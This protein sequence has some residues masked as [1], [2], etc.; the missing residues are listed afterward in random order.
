M[1][2][3]GKKNNKG[4][5]NSWQEAFALNQ[6]NIVLMAA[7]QYT[8]DDVHELF[9]FDKKHFDNIETHEKE[10]ND[11]TRKMN[12]EYL[13]LTMSVLCSRVLDYLAEE[14]KG[15][16]KIAI[17]EFDFEE[18][19]HISVSSIAKAINKSD[20]QNVRARLKRWV[21]DTLTEAGYIKGYDREREFSQKDH[22][23]RLT[24]E[25]FEAHLPFLRECGLRSEAFDGE[26]MAH[27]RSKDETEF[28]G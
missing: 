23:V 1:F 26:I 5:L 17:D 4:P 13:R 10:V 22:E 6:R 25:G 19:P 20:W 8:A 11:R 9:G 28:D 14:E 7:W 12:R 27:R 18:F 3:R 21:L 2:E 16:N 24:K 15:G